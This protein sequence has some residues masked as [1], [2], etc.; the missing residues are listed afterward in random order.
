M[1]RQQA[2]KVEIGIGLQSFGRFHQT[3]TGHDDA[4][5]GRDQIFSRAVL[6]RAHALLQGGVLHT[7]AFDSTVVKTRTLC[8][9]IHQ[10]VVGLVLQRHVVLVH[11][12]VNTVSFDHGLSLTFAQCTGGVVI[13]TPRPTTGVIDGHPK[14]PMQGMVRS[15]GHH[16][17]GGHDPRCDAPIILL[18]FRISSGAY[19]ETPLGIDHFKNRFEVVLVV[20]IAFG[21]FEQ[22]VVVQTA[23]VKKG[24]VTGVDAA[25]HGLQP[26]AFL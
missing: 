25:F 7:N 17:E 3:L 10:V 15:W 4:V 18:V 16:G 11:Q 1:L 5:V 24:D 21:A 19:K 22:G 12:H 9:A 8:V 2:W 14:V 23:A 13:K 6:N 20:L 26:V